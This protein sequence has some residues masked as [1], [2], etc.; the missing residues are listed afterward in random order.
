V[1]LQPPLAHAEYLGNDHDYFL[2]SALHPTQE[3]T[4]NRDDTPLNSKNP[5]RDALPDAV[6]FTFLDFIWKDRTLIW[7]GTVLKLTPKETAVVDILLRNS[8]RVVPLGKLIEAGWGNEPVG[9]ESLNRCISSLRRKV[10]FFSEHLQT[11]HRIG[12][13]LD[14]ETTPLQDLRSR[15]A[16]V[17][18]ASV[19][20]TARG[21]LGLQSSECCAAALRFLRNKVDRGV[22]D[23]D[24]FA[25]IA[26][27]ELARVINGHASP[28][29]AA[30]AAVSA[31]R[32]AIAG[33]H[34]HARAMSVI[35]FLNVVVSGD[36]TGL[37]L[38][39]DAVNADP[40]DIEVRFRKAWAYLSLNIPDPDELNIDCSDALLI[41]DD[42]DYR[43]IM[44]T[45]FLHEGRIDEAREITLRSVSYFPYHARNLFTAILVEYLLGDVEAAITIARDYRDIRSR[46]PNQTAPLLAFLLYRGGHTEEA[47]A[48]LEAAL[49]DTS[50]FRPSAFAVL[51]MRPI[52]GEAAA[53]SM[54]RK[55]KAAGCPHLCY[56][57]NTFAEPRPVDTAVDD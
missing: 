10:W 39:E 35:G 43:A 21:F 45:R 16:S 2:Q 25:M 26:E 12:Y 9:T 28:K 5:E 33:G 20:A 18:V 30:A 52:Q 42:Y 7:K 8:R 27:V 55:A 56:L 53:A 40:R 37:D 15:Q 3:L 49:G 19:V 13:S 41:V 34:P 57:F 1:P 24:V 54:L 44:A 29:S 51:A 31:A 38:L 46:N 50:R 17:D 22:T 14:L 36:S 47:T 23:P 48:V 4:L 32:R 6:D 11:H